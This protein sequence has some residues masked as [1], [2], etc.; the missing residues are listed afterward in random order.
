MIVI[1]TPALYH[2]LAIP[3]KGEGFERALDGVCSLLP[4]PRPVKVFNAQQPFATVG[5]RVKIAADRGNQRAE[6]QRT[7]RGRCETAPIVIHQTL[8]YVPRPF[9]LPW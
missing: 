4:R 1:Q 5:S 3:L 6:V 9:F 8:S 2:H 7:C